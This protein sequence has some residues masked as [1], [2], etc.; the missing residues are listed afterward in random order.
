MKKKGLITGLVLLLAGG[1][2][3]GTAYLTKG[4]QSV[5]E[6]VEKL[7]K[8]NYIKLTLGGEGSSTLD[9]LEYL[10]LSAATPVI[11]EVLNNE[12]IK[13]LEEGL[14]IGTFGSLSASGIL[15]FKTATK[16]SNIRLTVQNGYQREV[17]RKDLKYNVGSS[18][19]TL[20][21]EAALIYLAGAKNKDGIENPSVLTAKP[22]TKIFS[23]TSKNPTDYYN[24]SG[25]LGSF[26]LQS[27]EFWN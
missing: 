22:D 6:F 7:S 19:F 17:V 24:L 9:I 4:F 3:G 25:T 14:N 10:N 13:I 18:S 8:T 23:F 11:S 1:A 16:Y 12:D 26:Y 15:E 27:I 2:V 20:N 21:S 5:P